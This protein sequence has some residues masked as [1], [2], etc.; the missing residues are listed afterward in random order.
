MQ[1][2]KDMGLGGASV[3]SL[4]LDDFRGLCG[5]R[6]PLLSVVRRSL[7]AT[8]PNSLPILQAPDLVSGRCEKEGLYSDPHD[9]ASYYVCRAGHSFRVKCRLASLFDT[10]LG[11][12]DENVPPEKCRPGVS[13]HVPHPSYKSSATSPVARTDRGRKKVV[14]YVTN[15][16]FY[17]KGEGKFV[18][19][20]L[21][22]RLCTHIIWAFASLDPEQLTVK[23][24]DPWADIDNSK[25]KVFQI[26][27]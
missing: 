16:S 20:H 4:D 12:C 21:D 14:C 19:E 22:Q 7:S 27:T 23:E 10:S 1:Y 2:V 15:W 9:C 25:Y 8:V 18:P 11:R 13:I 17:R 6:Y 3:W 24:F 5:D 26:L